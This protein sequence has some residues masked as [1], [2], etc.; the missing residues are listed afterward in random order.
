MKTNELL[1]MHQAFFKTNATKDY[2]FRINALELLKNELKNN[3]KEILSAIAADLHK[4]TAE[5]YTT[6]Y[7]PAIREINYF[8]KNLKK[9]MKGQNAAFDLTSIS[10]KCRIYHEPKGTVLVITPWN[11]PF[12]LSMIPL[13]GSIAAGNTTIVKLNENTKQINEVIK[14]MMARSFDYCY[15]SVVDGDVNESKELVNLNFDHIFFTGSSSTGVEVMKAAAN[16]LVPVTLELG[17]KCPV[18]IDHETNLQDAADKI[19]WAKMLNSGQTCIAP[20]HVFVPKYLKENLIEHLIVAIEK[21]Y[22]RAKRVFDKKQLLKLNDMLDHI[23]YGG[24]SDEQ[25]NELEFTIT[26]GFNDSSKV[27]EIFGPILPIITYKRIEDVVKQVDT[28]LAIYLFSKNERNITY[29]Q[30]NTQSGALVIN[31]TAIYIGNN[32]L[33]FGGVKSSGMGRYHGQY[34]FYELTY[35]RAY[36]KQ[37]WLDVTP[38]VYPPSFGQELLRLIK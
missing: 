34:S 25:T 17:G 9:L 36:Y 3:K 31:N 22:E 19:I 11:Y 16:N 10:S 37:G 12:N 20:D 1:K 27:T 38:L 18:I 15:I 4:S 28:P 30:R 6:E 23:L 14:E 5:C 26:D 35:S 8:K 24:I 33:P 2:Q 32:K 13:I 21:R 29:I 7:L